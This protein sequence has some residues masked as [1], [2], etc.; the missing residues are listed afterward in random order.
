MKVTLRCSILAESSL[1]VG[2][3][4]AGLE[5][6]LAVPVPGECGL[7][8][9][10]SFCLEGE[11]DDRR[12]VSHSEAGLSLFGRQVGEAQ[13]RIKVSITDGDETTPM[14]N[15][16]QVV[17]WELGVLGLRSFSNSFVPMSRISFAASGPF[18]PPT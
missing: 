9:F 17:E 10:D 3:A 1:E 13:E 6:A 15:A 18:K 4:I 16:R 8:C 5:E 2:Q 7:E 14:G 11:F 12:Y